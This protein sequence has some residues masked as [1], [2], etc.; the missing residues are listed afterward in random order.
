MVSG[1]PC[2]DPRTPTVFAP[3]RD[4]LWRGV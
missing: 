2:D 1:G 3:D 4:A